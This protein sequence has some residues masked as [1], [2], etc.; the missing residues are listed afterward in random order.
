MIEKVTQEMVRDGLAYVE[1]YPMKNVEDGSTL[2][3]PGE[4]PDFYDVALRPDN[5]DD[6]DGMPYAEFEDLSLA[7]AIAKTYELEVAYPGISVEWITG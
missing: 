5:F 2:C 1:A 6:N 4:N 3:Q 7:E